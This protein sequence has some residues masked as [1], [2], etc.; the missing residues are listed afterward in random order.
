MA[1]LPLVYFPDPR[2]KQKGKP[3]E[4]ID[5]EIRQLVKDMFETMYH[6]RGVGLAAQQVGIVKQIFVMDVSENKSQP[7]CAI[8]PEIIS[9]EG[10]YAEYEGCLS[11]PGP[12]DK[13]PRSAKLRFKALDAEG[14]PYEMDAEGLMAQCVQHEID[15]LNGMLFVDHLSRLKQERARKKLEKYQRLRPSDKKAL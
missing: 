15:H 4:K 10:D 7:I 12:Y 3:I 1:L 2:L 6:E 9:R 11:Y 14:R 5:D 13:V 8:N